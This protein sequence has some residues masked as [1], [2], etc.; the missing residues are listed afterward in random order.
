MYT[1][2]TFKL[3]HNEIHLIDPTRLNHFKGLSNKMLEYF[4]FKL[5]TSHK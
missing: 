2:Q 5:L 3:E 1:N 4:L